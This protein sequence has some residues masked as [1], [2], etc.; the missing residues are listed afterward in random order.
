MLFLWVC[1]HPKSL[2]MYKLRVDLRDAEV[3]QQKNLL[4]FTLLYWK[5]F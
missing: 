3:K 2:Y 5:Y 4:N 1:F